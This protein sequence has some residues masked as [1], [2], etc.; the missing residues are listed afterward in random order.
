MS[1][2]TRLRQIRDN[3]GVVGLAALGVLGGAAFFFLVVLKPLEARN[4]QLERQLSTRLRQDTSASD[5]VRASTPA[6][7]LAAFYRYFETQEQTTDSLARLYAIGKEAGVELR[8]AGYRMQKAGVRIERYEIALPVTGSY[9]QIR[10]F[11]EKALL[12]IPVLSLDQVSFKR[13]NTKEALVH[14]DVRL[15]LHRVKP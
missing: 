2:S 15:T 12:Q 4:Q 8:S 11:L 9:A 13:Q 5:L 6:A 14:A 3:L 1:L 7:K 10:A